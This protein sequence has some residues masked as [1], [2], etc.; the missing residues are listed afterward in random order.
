MSML[1]RM[2]GLGRD[3]H[4]DKGLRLFDQGLYEEA[5]AE[6][7][8]IIPDGVQTGHGDALTERLA[9]FYIAEA[10]AK[11]GLEALESGHYDRARGALGSA[12]SINPHYADLHFH[13]G[14]ACRKA[15]DPQEA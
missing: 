5:I 10:Y 14:R 15:R 4:Y 13:Y 1:G 8:Q 7:E 2:F 3:E 6:L 9:A 11:M 12:L